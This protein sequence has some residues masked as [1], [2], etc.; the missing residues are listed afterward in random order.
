MKNNIINPKKTKCITNIKNSEVTKLMNKIFNKN[1][2]TN[3]YD[4]NEKEYENIKKELEKKDKEIWLII[5]IND[6]NIDFLM[7]YNLLKSKKTNIFTVDTTIQYSA[8]YMEKIKSFMGSKMSLFPK[9]K[10]KN[11]FANILPYNMENISE[12][13]KKS[14]YLFQG[15]TPRSGTTNI[16][17]NTSRYIS[18]KKKKNIRV[19]VIFTNELDYKQYFPDTRKEEKGILR[20]KEVNNE[21]DFSSKEKVIK[22]IANTVN[23]IDYFFLQKN[24]DFNEKNIIEIKKLIARMN[25]YYD[26]ILID[27]SNVENVPNI[28][29]L[30]ISQLE[31]TQVN[32]IDDLSVRSEL[33]KEKYKES[34]LDTFKN[35]LIINKINDLNRRTEEQ[36]PITK[37]KYISNISDQEIQNNVKKMKIDK[38]VENIEKT[39]GLEITNKNKIFGFFG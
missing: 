21:T 29:T 31:A 26:L 7:K 38:I 18:N 2:I 1:K 22:N 5:Q 16:V 23:K 12:L 4:E 15:I 35:E 27:G 36:K 3:I 25:E 11:E 13:S 8:P 19:G 28:Y 37:I 39:M 34:Y 9:V 17:I 6:K 33:V 32:I 30:A 24:M 20:V 14:I 10:T